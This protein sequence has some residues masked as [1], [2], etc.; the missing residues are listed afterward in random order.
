MV[1]EV[2]IMKYTY[3]HLLDQLSSTVRKFNKCVEYT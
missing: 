2:N 1:N 3:T